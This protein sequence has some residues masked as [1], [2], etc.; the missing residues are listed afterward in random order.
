VKI[1]S[2]LASLVLAL[3]VCSATQAALLNGKTVAYQYYFPTIATPY[4]DPG[5]GFGMASNGNHLVGSGIEV[6]N[7]TDTM[8]NMDISDTNLFVQFNY[9]S[10]FYASDFS[11][12]RIFDVTNSISDF[13]SVTINSV[14]NM[15]DFDAS[16]ITFDTD[17]IWVN[18][19]G[20]SF[21]ENT[22]LSIDIVGKQEEVPEPA[23]LAL[24]GFALLG[25]VGTLRRR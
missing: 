2:I 12:F 7:V 1:K 9:D 24:L 16:R 19:Q 25:M 4:G 10:Y 18:L 20:L 17:N 23:T 8:A 11:G 14:T 6:E 21:N 15:V 5:N 3:G 13:L 22:V